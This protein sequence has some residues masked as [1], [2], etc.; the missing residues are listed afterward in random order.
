MLTNT[1]DA[2]TNFHG[3]PRA[4]AATRQSISI[5]AAERRTVQGPSAKKFFPL[6]R[7]VR[8]DSLSLQIIPLSLRERVGVR[9]VCSAVKP[10]GGISGGFPSPRPSP[11]GRGGPPRALLTG[12]KFHFRRS[13]HQL[14]PFGPAVST[15]RPGVRHGHRVL[16][17]GAGAAVRRHLGPVVGLASHLLAAHVHHR[18]DGDDQPGNEAEIAAA[19]ELGLA[20][21]FGT[22]GSS[23]IFRPMPW[24]T[25][26]ST[27][28]KPCLAT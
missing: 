13:A 20:T 8:Q 27:T 4:P 12:C 15:S 2:G 7:F 1:F 22:C 21:K 10:N 3:L 24:P 26:A 28:E 19:A 14:S 9:G 17:M 6:A 16:E 18:L 5:Y 25:N 23:C 11:G